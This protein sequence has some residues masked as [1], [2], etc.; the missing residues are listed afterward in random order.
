MVSFHRYNPNIVNN[1]VPYTDIISSGQYREGSDGYSYTSHGY[2]G[3]ITVLLV[4]VKGAMTVCPIG[5]KTFI[6]LD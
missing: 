5:L 2:K 6:S 3:G 4:K 1:R